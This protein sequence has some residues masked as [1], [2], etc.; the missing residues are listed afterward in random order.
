MFETEWEKSRIKSWANENKNPCN[1]P[2]KGTDLTPLS[3]DLDLCLCE[4]IQM[5]MFVGNKIFTQKTQ[6]VIYHY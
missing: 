3:Y 1:C 6:L 4:M 2:C 5:H